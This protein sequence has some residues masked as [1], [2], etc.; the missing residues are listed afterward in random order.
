ML[1][2]KFRALHV[3]IPRPPRLGTRTLER[4]LSKPL[5]QLGTKQSMQ[6][7]IVNVGQNLGQIIVEAICKELHVTRKASEKTKDTLRR[8]LLIPVFTLQNPGAFARFVARAQHIIDVV[9]S[10]LTFTIDANINRLA[11]TRTINTFGSMSPIEPNT[12]RAMFA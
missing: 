2:R 9:L 11:C 1:D 12:R 7:T 4:I 3:Q 10:P 5:T 8:Q 6:A